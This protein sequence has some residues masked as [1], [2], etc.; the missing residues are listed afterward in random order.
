MELVSLRQLKRLMKRGIPFLRKAAIEELQDLDERLRRDI[1]EG[2]APKPGYASLEEQY[3]AKR[4]LLNEKITWLYQLTMLEKAERLGIEIDEKH[5]EN[6]SDALFPNL[7]A[8]GRFWLRKA[9]RDDRRE[10]VRFWCA[11]FLPI[12]AILVSIASLVISLM[13]RHQ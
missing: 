1:V 11:I 12:L 6:S 9:L 2:K 3:I 4:K 10:S 5:F 8:S 7:T 13:H